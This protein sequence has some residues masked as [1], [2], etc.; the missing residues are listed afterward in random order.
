[1]KKLILAVPIILFAS[2]TGVLLLFVMECWIWGWGV[3]ALSIVVNWWSESFACNLFKVVDKRGD[4]R[5]LTFNINRAYEKSV[6]KGTIDDLIDF[7]LHQNADIV[8]LQ[9]YNSEIYPK[10]QS[11]LSKVYQYDSDKGSN[12]RF[13]SV[14]SNYPIESCEQLMVDTSDGQYDLFQKPFYSKKR[15]EN[16]E[17]LPICKLKIRIKNKSVYLYNCHLMSNNYTVV[18]RT[19]RKKNKKPWQGI[20][21]ALKRIDFGYKARDLQVEVISKQIN[22]NIPTIICGDFND[23]GGASCIRKLQKYCLS[24]AWWKGGFGFGFTYHGMKL[25]LRLDHVLYSRKNLQLTR[26]LIPHSEVS[27]HYPIVCDFN[28]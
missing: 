26:V 25:R 16:N 15:F 14:F 12:S 17:V 7:I 3:L 28:L 10:V 1:M 22:V 24:D 11:C 13:K 19:L 4:F 6:N 8:L 27:D 23:V 2:I 21:P 5:I 9:E 20:L 18:M